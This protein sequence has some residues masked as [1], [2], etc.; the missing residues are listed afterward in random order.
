MTLV[1]KQKKQELKAIIEGHFDDMNRVKEHISNLRAV[2]LFEETVADDFSNLN[3]LNF[4][5]ETIMDYLD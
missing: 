3:R 5:R 4:L 2:L 1:N